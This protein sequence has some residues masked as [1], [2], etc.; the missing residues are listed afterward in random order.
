MDS[1]AEKKLMRTLN[2]DEKEDLFA[3]LEKLNTGTVTEYKKVKNKKTGKMENVQISTPGLT[4][5]AA[6]ATIEQKL[7]DLNPDDADRTSRIKF[8]D[9]LSGSVEGI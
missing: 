2:D 6:Q 4:S 5:E 8:A 7:I 1:W 3:E 9:W